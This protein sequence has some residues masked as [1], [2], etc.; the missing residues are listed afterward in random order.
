MFAQFDKDIAYTVVIIITNNTIP[1]KIYFSFFQGEIYKMKER[2]I[3]AG[4]R[5]FSSNSRYVSFNPYIKVLLTHNHFHF[6]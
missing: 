3:K 2:R 6:S 4:R 1:S 5:K